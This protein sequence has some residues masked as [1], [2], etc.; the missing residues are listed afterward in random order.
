MSSIGRSLSRLFVSSFFAVALAHC[1]L[2][3]Q[4]NPSGS[5]APGSSSS[6]SSGYSE[7]PL[8]L[9]PESSWTANGGTINAVCPGTPNPRETGFT[10]VGSGVSLATES[11]AVDCCTCAARTR[12]FV[13]PTTSTSGARL[14]GTLT[15]T[16]GQSTVYAV[17]SMRVTLTKNGSDIADRVLAGESRPN[18]NCAGSSERP[19]VIVQGAFDLDLS[20]FA[21]G[22]SFDGVRIDLMGYGCGLATA[23]A[24]LEDLRLATPS[25]GSPSAPPSPPPSPAPGSG[26][27]PDLTTSL[28]PDKWS[29]YANGTI[30]RTNTGLAGVVN[31]GS[32][33]AHGAYV[34]IRTETTNPAGAPIRTADARCVQE[35]DAGLKCLLGDVAPGA[36]TT[37][38]FTFNSFASTAVVAKSFTTDVD[39][40]PANDRTVGHVYPQ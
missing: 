19:E 32:T 37:V 36:S 33:T 1:T 4:L 20:A 31:Q 13:V 3:T 18:N 6:A 29:S 28:T 22:A 24:T 26:G 21:A 40:N 16:R 35:Y 2:P 7:L 34:T 5:G 15:T 14:R 25:G 9:L 10:Q 27:A 30:G 8:A 39:A 12:S 23:E 11:N 38:A 17:A